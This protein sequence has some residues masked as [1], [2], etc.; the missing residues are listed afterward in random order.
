LSFV[1]A[2]LNVQTIYLNLIMIKLQNRGQ[3]L[4]NGEY[5]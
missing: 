1:S 4:P 3:L 2:S 5:Y